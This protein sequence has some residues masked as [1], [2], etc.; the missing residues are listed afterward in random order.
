MHE[1]DQLRDTGASRDPDGAARRAFGNITSVE[2][3]Y[4][5][6]RALDVL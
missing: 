4:Y 2:E 1:A 3:A 5:E 6:R